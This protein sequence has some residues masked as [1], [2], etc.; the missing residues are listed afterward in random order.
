MSVALSWLSGLFLL[1]GCFL[2]ITGAVGFLRF[3]DFYARIHACGVT[4]TLATSLILIG[5]MLQADGALSLFK[6]FMVLLFLLFTSPTASHALAKA[7]WTAGVRP[8][9]RRGITDLAL[10]PDER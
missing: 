9:G 5:L 2:L 4:E 3:R 7:A 10:A 1:L 6:L 8:R